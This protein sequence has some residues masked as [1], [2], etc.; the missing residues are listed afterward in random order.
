MPVKS[1]KPIVT[2]DSL[3]VGEVNAQFFGGNNPTFPPVI[4]GFEPWAKM[5]MVGALL[6][7]GIFAPSAPSASSSIQ[8][9][10]RMK[11]PFID[12]KL[13]P[14]K[15]IRADFH[16]DRVELEIDTKVI[17]NSNPGYKWKEN[18]KTG[19]K[20]DI[21]QVPNSGAFFGV[22]KYPLQ[23]LKNLQVD[24]QNGFKTIVPKMNITVKKKITKRVGIMGLLGDIWS[25]WRRKRIYVNTMADV[26]VKY[27]WM[28][29]VQ[30]HTCKLPLIGDLPVEK[31]CVHFTR[32]TKKCF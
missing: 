1:G 13:E 8:L 18:P 32:W 15:I 10:D 9:I 27:N 26:T 25:Y 7:N 31:G 24:I 21:I 2:Y 4:F 5:P 6:P 14:L 22:F 11:P 16:A 19:E 20:K 12:V 23:I 28:G 30:T 29:S 3:R 17:N